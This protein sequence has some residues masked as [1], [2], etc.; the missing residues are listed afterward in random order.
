MD[1]DKVWGGFWEGLGRG[2]GNSGRILNGLGAAWA[3]FELCAGFCVS[4]CTFSVFFMHFWKD[5]EWSGG[6]LGAVGALWLHAST[7]PVC[8]RSSRSL[9]RQV[10]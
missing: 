5:F 2:L 8:L 6:S 3:L 9:L 7:T 1:L 10:N 4:F